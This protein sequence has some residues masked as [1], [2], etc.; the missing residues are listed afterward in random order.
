M[1]PRFILWLTWVN[2]GWQIV[3]NI[4]WWAGVRHLVGA[5]LGVWSEVL[6]QGGASILPT[7][8]V[9]AI[10]VPWSFKLIE[11]LQAGTNP[12]KSN[13]SDL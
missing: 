10:V 3:F 6:V 12:L 2:A 9:A 11:S 7:L 4:A 5:R 8:V 13:G 1:S